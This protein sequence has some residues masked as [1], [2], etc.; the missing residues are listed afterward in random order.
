MADQWAEFA[1]APTA[2][3]PIAADPWAEFDDA[4]KSK[5][6]AKPKADD[7][8]PREHKPI[9]TLTPTGEVY[10][11][12]TFRLEGGSLARLSGVDAF[13][14]KQAGRNRAGGE[15]PLGFLARSYLGGRTSPDDR[16]EDTGTRSYNRPVVTL[17]DQGEDVGRGVI[18][19]GLGL[20]TPEY[21]KGDAVRLPEYME[22]ER[23]ARLRR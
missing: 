17:R 1:D 15:V 10:D 6:K 2:A 19:Q 8:P 11:G 4:P 9:L 21:L 22:A 3:P 23:L 16:V 12:D 5:S 7:L 20:A 13:E 14:L 18:D